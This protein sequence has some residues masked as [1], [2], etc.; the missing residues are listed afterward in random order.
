M[1]LFKK[2]KKK[3]SIKNISPVALVA[4]TVKKPAQKV[5]S[6]GKLGVKDIVS[7]SPIGV[8]TSVV[9]SATSNVV[10]V[11]VDKP[12]IEKGNQD[13][14]KED[15]VVDNT[16]EIKETATLKEPITK[17][18]DK[19]LLYLGIGVGV[20]LLVAGVVYKMRKK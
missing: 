12:L 3:I 4:S 14:F 18:D 15:V 19:K 13:S 11:V 10:D 1:G 6:T 7:V 2:L 20:L 16:K 8:T 9:K 5:I 17:E